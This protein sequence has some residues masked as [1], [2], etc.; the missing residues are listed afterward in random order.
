MTSSIALS[1]NL[2]TSA[3]KVQRNPR[4]SFPGPVRG[5]STVLGVLTLLLFVV[6]VVISAGLLTGQLNVQTF[7]AIHLSFCL[8]VGWVGVRNERRSGST[9]LFTTH[10][11]QL[12]LWTLMAGPFGALV[13]AAFLLPARQATDRASHSSD[14]AEPATIEMPDERLLRIY[15]AY[16]DNRIRVS[17]IEQAKG[18]L[19]LIDVIAEGSR[20]E[21]LEALA[22]I[23]RG[24]HP[25]FAP[26][27]KCAM[28]DTDASVRV[29][30]ATVLAK[31]HGTFTQRIGA[32]QR[33]NTDDTSVEQ[34]CQLAEARLDYAEAG[35][36]EASRA[37]AEARQAEHALERAGKADVD[38]DNILRIAR[39]SRRVHRRLSGALPLSVSEAEPEE[40][41][42]Q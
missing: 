20:N 4:T 15:T 19:P 21:K 41:A 1:E 28:M 10:A 7:A 9:G 6:E 17:R 40:G 34:L 37:R 8:T 25:C 3:A 11:F 29:L 35:L 26:A 33:V 27:I 32:L 16:L 36:M 13:S 23:A 42:G 39:L 5:G 38:R 18:V 31:L 30:A 12:L 2:P 24:Y 22:V 14:D